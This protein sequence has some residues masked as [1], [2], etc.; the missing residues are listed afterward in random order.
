[1]ITFTLATITHSFI[2]N[3][4]N[5]NFQYSKLAQLNSYDY[6]ESVT[7]RKKVKYELRCDYVALKSPDGFI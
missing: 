6:V 4:I 3:P 1:M 7:Q 2:H 5:S